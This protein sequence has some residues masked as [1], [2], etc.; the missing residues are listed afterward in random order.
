M[1]S[2]AGS[3]HFFNGLLFST[4]AIPHSGPR[5]EYVSHPASSRRQCSL[6]GNWIV[7]EPLSELDPAEGPAASTIG[8]Q[9]LPK[10]RAILGISVL[11]AP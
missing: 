7:G 8:P 3:C 10:Y 6:R 9:E 4:R 5:G 2:A 1:P 11:F